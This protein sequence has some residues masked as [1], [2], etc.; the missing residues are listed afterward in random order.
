MITAFRRTFRSKRCRG[1]QAS[2]TPDAA[3][4]PEVVICGAGIIG[5]ATAYY[6]AKRGVASTLI[7]RVGVAAAAS[8]R[9]GGF[10]AKDWNDAS[11]VG[12]LAR[13]SFDLHCGLQDELGC[14]ID[15]RCGAA[16]RLPAEVPAVL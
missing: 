6:L 12:P 2:A 7:D 16:L 1:R 15:F 4:A 3:P 8:G 10:L 14:E 9:A 13:L 5:A 11:P